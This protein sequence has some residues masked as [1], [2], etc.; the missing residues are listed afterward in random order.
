VIKE[1][2][3]VDVAVSALDRLKE[4]HERFVQEIAARSQTPINGGSLTVEEDQILATCLGVSLRVVHRPIARNGE[5]EALEYAFIAQYGKEELAVWHLYLE[6]NGVLYTDS[7]A[8]VRFCDFNNAY[9]ANK[10]I[11]AL[12]DALL[13]SSVFA[14]H[15]P[16][17]S[18]P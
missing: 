18:A 6:G 15:K 12:A 14:P 5:L 7:S 17:G 3:K 2:M 9:V 1:K 16:F 8:T 4:I 11:A 13:R 10:I